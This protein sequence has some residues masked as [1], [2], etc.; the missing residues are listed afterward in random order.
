MNSIILRKI[1]ADFRNF[2]LQNQQTKMTQIFANNISERGLKPI[3]VPALY[4]LCVGICAVQLLIVFYQVF[5]SHIGR[6]LQ[7]HDM[8]YRGSNIGQ[9]TILYGSAVVVGNVDKW[10]G[11]K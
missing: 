3:V 5:A 4:Y 10:Y 2:L 9:T 6:L 11:V 7:A 8:Q 1:F